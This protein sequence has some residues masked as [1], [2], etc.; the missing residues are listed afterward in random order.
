MSNPIN[1]Y[2]LAT[3]A[4]TSAKTVLYRFAPSTGQAP[5]WAGRGGSIAT[6][7]IATPITDPAWWLG[8]YALCELMISDEAGRSLVIPLAVVSLSK[9]KHIVTTQVVGMAGTV[10]EYISDGDYEL[11]IEV[12][13]QASRDGAIVDEYPEEEMRHLVSFLDKSEVLSVHSTFLEIFGIDRIV[14]KGYSSQQMTESN[15]QYMT[16]T[17]ISDN[18]Y[19]VYSTDY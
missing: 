8:R 3:T 1:P 17:A 6:S 12:G 18:E 5:S 13:L 19:N 2:I 7:S 14:I 10:K 16:I 11:S 4:A 9:T 15:I